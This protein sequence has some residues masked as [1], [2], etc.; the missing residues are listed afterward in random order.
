MIPGS[1]D[2]KGRRAA[3]RGGGASVQGRIRARALRPGREP[4]G[5]G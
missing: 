1:M 4:R 3:E 5:Q 2:E